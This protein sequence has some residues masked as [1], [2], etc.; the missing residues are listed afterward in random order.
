MPDSDEELMLKAKD[1]D[2]AAFEIL[3]KRYM[4]R[5]Y[6]VVLSFT[7]DPEVSW[8]LSQDAFVSVFKF[9][10]KFNPQYRFYPWFYKILKNQALNYIR[11]RRREAN[12][13][14]PAL[15]I[16]YN[17]EVIQERDERKDAVWKAI[18]E[19]EPEERELIILR[20]FQDLSYKEIAQALDCPL[21]TVMSRLY[22]ARKK[23]KEKVERWL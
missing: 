21:G 13:N 19:L 23:L 17:P 16:L 2:I 5:A 10:R 12:F 7:G 15:D 11:K 20:H 18:W 14:G 6:F 1:G 9:L 4:K 3:V 22:Y 8:D